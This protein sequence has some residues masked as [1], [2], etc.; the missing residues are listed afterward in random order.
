MQSKKPVNKNRLFLINYSIV[1][2]DKRC[3]RQVLHSTTIIYWLPTFSFLHDFPSPCVFL[4]GHS[5]LFF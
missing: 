1:R 3:C 5:D 4:Q 2:V